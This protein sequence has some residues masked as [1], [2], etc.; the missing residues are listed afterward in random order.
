MNKLEQDKMQERFDWSL[1]MLQRQAE[2]M[3]ISISDDVLFT[4]ASEM[5]RCLFVRSEIQYSG[6]SS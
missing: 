6:R 2:A 1:A 5:A 3:N 4:Q